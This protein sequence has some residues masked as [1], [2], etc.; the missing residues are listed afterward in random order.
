MKKV[1]TLISIFSILFLVGISQN[2]TASITEKHNKVVL[3]P[4]EELGLQSRGGSSNSNNTNGFKCG[5]SAITLNGIVYKTV[6]FQG[7]CWFDRNLGAERVAIS[8]N[9]KKSFGDYY[10]WGRLIDGS[11]SKNSITT[12]LL[13]EVDNPGC[14]CFMTSA[15]PPYDWHIP[16]KNS[17]W[18][19]NRNNPCPT[20]WRVASKSD[21]DRLLSI[22]SDLFASPL[23][24]PAS[25]YRDG[26]T[27]KIRE[28]GKNTF[29]WSSTP[30]GNKASFLFCDGN[31]QKIKNFTRANGLPVRC[32]KSE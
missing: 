24:I 25:G 11:E 28:Y 22:N 6:F 18:K 10:Q 27:G 26:A 30:V 29:L 9:D 7:K 4:D 17:L 3:S 2:F 5:E 21:F 12:K 32:V 13:S 20:G 1:I 16:Q 15:S 14:S 19:N 8:R 23:K 31:R